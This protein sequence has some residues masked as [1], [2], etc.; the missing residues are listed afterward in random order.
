[1]SCREGG[2]G[3]KTEKITG[4]IRDGRKVKKCIC[5]PLSLKMFYVFGA[6]FSGRLY[7][8]SICPTGG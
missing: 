6:K 1:M 2:A 7:I 8:I 3:M 4:K 5:L